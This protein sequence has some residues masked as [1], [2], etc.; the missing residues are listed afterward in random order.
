MYCQQN[1]GMCTGLSLLNYVHIKIWR[2][3]NKIK[4]AA[5]SISPLCAVDIKEG[6]AIGYFPLS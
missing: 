1:K 5:R 6:R 4:S 3:N 2:A